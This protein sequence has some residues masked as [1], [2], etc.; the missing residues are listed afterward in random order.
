LELRMNIVFNIWIWLSKSIGTACLVAP[1][2]KLLPQMEDDVPTS[3]KRRYRRPCRRY[4]SATGG[5]ALSVLPIY[6]ECT[7]SVH[8]SP[9]L[10]S[11]LFRI[12][13]EF[14]SLFSHFRGNS[15]LL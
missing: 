8:V 3:P 12:V 4:L 5:D 2:W 15:K 6:N 13:S 11:S 7:V 14:L 1:V 9:S 10:F